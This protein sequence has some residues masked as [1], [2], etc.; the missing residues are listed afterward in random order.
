MDSRFLASS[1]LLPIFLEVTFIHLSSEKQNGKGA[2]PVRSLLHTLIHYFS[3]SSS[4]RSC[5]WWKRMGNKVKEALQYGVHMVLSSLRRKFQKEK[6]DNSNGPISG[7]DL[8][9]RF[10]DSTPRRGRMLVLIPNGLWNEL[11]S[12]TPI[13]VDQPEYTWLWIRPTWGSN[14]HLLNCPGSYQSWERF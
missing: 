12:I 1:P 10:P 14:Y 3:V 6:K 8:R 4:V 13:N 5:S 2:A 11:S 9:C 7:C